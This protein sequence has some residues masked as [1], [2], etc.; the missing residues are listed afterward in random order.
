MDTQTVFNVIIALSGGLGGF[1]LKLI[2]DA[3]KTLQST[4][5]AMAAD[6]SSLK[7]MVAGQY[8]TRDEYKSDLTDIKTALQRIEDKLDSKQ[9]K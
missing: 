7:V 4:D 5:T 9:D 6:L 2:W 1:V 8:I 3:I